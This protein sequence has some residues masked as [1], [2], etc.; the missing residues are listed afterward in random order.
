MAYL[1][2]KN[3]IF[4]EYKREQEKVRMWKEA[5]K[6]KRKALK[7]WIKE[8]EKKKAKPKEW[9]ALAVVSVVNLIIV[10]LII[11]AY[12]LFAKSLVAD[13][14]GNRVGVGEYIMAVSYTQSYDDLQYV[15][16]FSDCDQALAYYNQNCVDANIMMC[17][18]QDYIYL[19]IGFKSDVP[20][21]FEPTEKQSCGFVGVQ[22]NK[23]TEAK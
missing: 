2:Y 18:Q 15:A 14:K 16:H 8:N 20:F 13:E 12:G 3:K 11:V 23:F 5:E 19:P 6:R 21:D 22:E 4:R 9:L 1:G 7:A 17:Q 10:A